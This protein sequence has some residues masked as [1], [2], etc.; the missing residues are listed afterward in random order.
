MLRL[1]KGNVLYVLHNSEEIRF[2]SKLKHNLSREN[3]LI[4]SMISDNKKWHYLAVKGLSALLRR[5]ISNDYGD[6]YC[7]NCLHLFRT[8]NKLKEHE[9]I[10]EN[11][12]QCY[13]K[14]LKHNSEEKSMKVPFIIYSDLKSLLDNPK[15]SSA[16]KINKHTASG[17]SLF[18]HCSFDA[19]KN[20]LDYYRI[21][22]C[23][24]ECGRISKGMQHT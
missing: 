21:H 24:K 22:D 12:D 4:L 16:T 5:I 6:F 7:L 3:K 1:E 19:T 11:H 15:N 14:T 18:A 23:M 8:E 17:Y 20:K 13:N 9:N 2:T 10:C